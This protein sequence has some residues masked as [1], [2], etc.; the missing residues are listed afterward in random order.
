[1]A[2][3]MSCLVRWSILLST[4]FTVRL[5]GMVAS[6]MQRSCDMCSLLLVSLLMSSKV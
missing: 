2:C 4:L 5:K 1:M 3:L 6:R